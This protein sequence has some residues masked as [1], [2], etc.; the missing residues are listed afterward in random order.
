ME[1][2]TAIYYLEYLTVNYLRACVRAMGQV[3]EM[4]NGV[5]WGRG[6][7]LNGFVTDER[8]ENG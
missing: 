3:V 2:L 5:K 7:V 1:Y 4:D 8:I 6:V